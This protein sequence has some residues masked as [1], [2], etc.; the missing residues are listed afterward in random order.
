MC[1][2]EIKV[3]SMFSSFK[4]VNTICSHVLIPKF[5]LRDLVLALPPPRSGLIPILTTVC[6]ISSYCD[7]ASVVSKLYQLRAGGTTCW[8]SRAGKRGDP[9]TT[10]VP[11]QLWRGRLRLTGA[12]AQGLQGT[13]LLSLRP[14]TPAA[15]WVTRL[16]Q[17]SHWQPP[18]LPLTLPAIFK[19]L[20]L[21]PQ[22]AG[23]SPGQFWKD[24]PHS[25]SCKILLLIPTPISK[26]AHLR[27]AKHEESTGP[28]NKHSP[29]L[30][31]LSNTEKQG[32]RTLRE[33]RSTSSP[34][35]P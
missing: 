2:G 4:D 10:P 31:E 7:S 19:A 18:P 33:P 13:V 23:W 15:H 3:I 34:H 26:A 20:G 6:F 35:L 8:V 22:Y 21:S 1:L 24:F 5:V 12:K 28:M 32:P 9:L 11:C 25:R 29:S 17:M 30:T 27:Q 14:G 16:Q